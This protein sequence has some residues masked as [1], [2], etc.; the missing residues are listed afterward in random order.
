M[1]GEPN[2]EGTDA[3]EEPATAD[4]PADADSTGDDTEVDDAAHLDSLPDG[5][6]CTEVWE[7]LSESRGDE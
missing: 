4:E 2:D 3:T 6:G 1:D 7:Y 5:A